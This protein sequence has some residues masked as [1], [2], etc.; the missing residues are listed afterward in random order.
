MIHPRIRG[1]S[2]YK[3][4]TT[5]CKVKLSSNELP[6]KFPEEVKR[7]IGEVVSSLPLNRY[8]DPQATELKEVIAKRF[9]VS[10]DNLVLGNGSDELI[11][12]LTIAVGELSSPVLYPVPTFPMYGICATAL[13]REK[14][15][16]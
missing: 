5:P 15:E 10:T 3:T 4:E 8:P 13:G 6:I 16:V 14:V 2:A 9:G 11:Q 7:K 1:L 12:Y